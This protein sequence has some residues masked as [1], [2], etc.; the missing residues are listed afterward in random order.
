MVWICHIHDLDHQMDDQEHDTKR[1]VTRSRSSGVSI[2][3][4][5]YLCTGTGTSYSTEHGRR[6]DAPYYHTT[7]QWLWSVRC[8]CPETMSTT[9]TSHHPPHPRDEIGARVSSGGTVSSTSCIHSS[10]LHSSIHLRCSCLYTVVLLVHGIGLPNTDRGMES[11]IV[12]RVA[13][14][15]L[16]PTWHSGAC[17]V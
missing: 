15:G 17:P 11:S 10:T 7:S 6:T 2:M 16:Y 12:W 9:S 4:H 5:M 1:L 13:I 8:L 14:L 3:C